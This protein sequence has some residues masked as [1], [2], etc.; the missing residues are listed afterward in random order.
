[1]ME[2]FIDFTPL[3]RPVD[4][5]RQRLPRCIVSQSRGNSEVGGSPGPGGGA[6]AGEG[7]GAG[8]VGAHMC[9]VGGRH[10]A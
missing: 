10:P 2:P 4:A 5:G 9:E 6:A 8:G 3:S 1:M 7:R